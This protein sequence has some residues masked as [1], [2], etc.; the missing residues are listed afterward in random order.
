MSKRCFVKY[1]EIP[2]MT[3]S[4]FISVCASR[5][6]YNKNLVLCWNDNQLIDFL[7][8]YLGF[9]LLVRRNKTLWE[10]ATNIFINPNWGIESWN[11]THTWPKCQGS[12][13]SAASSLTI[14]SLMFITVCFFFPQARQRGK[15][16]FIQYIIFVTFWHGTCNLSVTKQ[17]RI[18][19]KKL[20]FWTHGWY[21]VVKLIL[22]YFFCK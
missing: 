8:L 14:L 20:A 4:G 5:H 3:S 13:A 9:V 17:T 15:T 21:L 10:S 16:A 19:P 2:L 18:S 12:T 22:N 11:L 1:E 7:C 6:T